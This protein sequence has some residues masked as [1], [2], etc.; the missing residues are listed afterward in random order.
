MFGLPFAR[1]QPV[2]PH[3]LIVH[4]SQ[5]SDLFYTLNKDL[6]KMR[7]YGGRIGLSDGGR[8]LVIKVGRNARSFPSCDLS[9]EDKCHLNFARDTR[10]SGNQEGKWAYPGVSTE[11]DRNKEEFA[12]MVDIASDC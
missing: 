6:Y 7:R 5:C 11:T 9:V 1:I 4:R 2:T 3:L 8:D 12:D 10:P